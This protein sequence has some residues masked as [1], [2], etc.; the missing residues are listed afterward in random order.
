MEIHKSKY[1]SY[2]VDDFVDLPMVSHLDGHAENTCKKADKK[3]MFHHLFT[4]ES[5]WEEKYFSDSK[6]F[7][8]QYCPKLVE[9][10]GDYPHRL[11]DVEKFANLKYQRAKPSEEL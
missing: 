4:P 11:A 6:S 7:L 2:I 3:C 10:F 9:G 5:F 8:E 1:K